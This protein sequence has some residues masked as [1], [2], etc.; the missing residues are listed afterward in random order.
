MLLQDEDILN[1][2]GL[3]LELYLNLHYQKQR[4]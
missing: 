4:D 1:Y 2:L 3:G